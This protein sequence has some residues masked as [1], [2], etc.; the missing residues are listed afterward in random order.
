MTESLLKL[1]AVVPF[2]ECPNC[3]ELLE[4]GVAT[5][6]R[7]REEISSEYA[8][9]SAVVVHHNTQACSLANSIASFDAFIPLALVGGIAI[10][11]IDWWVSDAPRIS[12][13]ILFWPIMPLLAISLW[14]IRFGRFK[15]GDEE[16]LQAR[17]EMKRSFAFWLAMLIVQLLLVAVA[18]LRWPAI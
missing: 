2:V 17:R 5:C 9:V 11:A 6:P 18:W 1:P 10:Y 12:L 7:C 8:L 13:G 3:K 16:Y 15:I 4:L 14:H